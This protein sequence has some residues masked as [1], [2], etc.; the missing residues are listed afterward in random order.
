M[1][2]AYTLHVLLLTRLVAQGE[3]GYR[4]QGKAKHDAPLSIPINCQCSKQ[5]RNSDRVASF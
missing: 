2:N 5:R 3:H 4:S 1:H